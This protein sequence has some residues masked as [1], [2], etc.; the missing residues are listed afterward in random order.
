MVASTADRKI[1]LLENGAQVAEG[2]IWFKLIEIKIR[3]GRLSRISENFWGI[4]AMSQNIQLI[5]GLVLLWSTTLVTGFFRDRLGHGVML[6]IVLSGLLLTS[7]AK[8]SLPLAWRLKLH[9]HKENQ[10]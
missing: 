6:G 4:H 3:H 5:L 8:F 10:P 1:D 2:R 7:V 9:R